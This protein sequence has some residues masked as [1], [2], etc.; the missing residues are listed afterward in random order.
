M[1]RDISSQFAPSWYSAFEGSHTQGREQRMRAFVRLWRAFMRARVFIAAVLL[2]MQ[3]FMV[4]SKNDSAG[5]L[6]LLCSLHL[7][8]TLIVLYAWRPVEQGRP[9]QLQW[10]MTI[11]VDVVV[12]ALLQSF[13]VASIN[14][15]AL[16]AL[17]V[18]LASILGPLIL[19]LATA[20]SVTLYL[21]GEAALSATLLGDMSTSRFLQA[22]LTGTGFFLVAVLANQL[23]IRLAREEAVAASSQAVAR[24]QAQVNELVIESLTVGV[25]VVDPHGVVRNANPAAQ[26][27]LLGHTSPQAAKLLL[28]ARPSWHHLA[29]IVNETFA[30]GEA[31]EMETTIDND[32]RPSQRLHARTR[33]TAQH[34]RR[35]GLCVLFLED[36]REVEAR[37]RTEKLASMGRMSAAVAHEIRNPLSAITQ[38]NALLDEEVQAPAQ[39]RLTR[40]IEQNAQ[41]LSRIVDDVLNVARAQPSQDQASAPALPLDQT[42]RQITHEWARQNRAERILGV[43]VHAAAAHIGFDPE[44]LRRLLINLLDNAL[45]HASGKPSSIRVI[46]QP[47]GSEHIRLSVWSDGQ[48]LE[49]SVM[50]HLFEPFFSSESRSSGLGLYICRELCERYGAQIAYRR[51]R[52]DQ[53]EGNEFYALIPSRGPGAS[54]NREPTQQSLPYPGD[55]V[56]TRTVQYGGPMSGDAPLATR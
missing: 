8:S 45:R 42:V 5:W 7:C 30:M 55:S 52:L 22:A 12:F 49:A 41:R 47:S 26:A 17:P 21:L 50:R 1:A 40:M 16:F 51:T 25:L 2:A 53:R 18:L 27:M 35:A 11:G 33:L 34:G 23:A 56:V 44:H 39:K 15:T 36:L 19:A 31:L 43:H 3:V 24:A 13:Q 6:V 38:A 29:H 9:L 32:D 54:S 37:V 28:S 4:V 46:T 48:A 10:L 14:Y 20:A